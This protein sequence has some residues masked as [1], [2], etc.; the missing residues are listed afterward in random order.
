MKTRD[1]LIREVVA[2]F[3]LGEERAMD[4]E[5]EFHELLAP[6]LAHHQGDPCQGLYSK[7]DGG[8][9]P[10]VSY[11]DVGDTYGDTLL[12]DHRKG[13]AI[14]MSLGDWLAENEDVD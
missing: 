7:T 3:A 14:R 10:A 13:V 9:W 4:Y 12:Y 8:T 1:E 5:T 2:T 11:L 6:L